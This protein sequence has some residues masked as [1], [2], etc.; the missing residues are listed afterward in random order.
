MASS[1]NSDCYHCLKSCT[2]LADL[3]V[4]FFASSYLRA[5]IQS[6]VAKL[7]Y[8]SNPSFLLGY[9]Q[10]ARSSVGLEYRSPKP[11]V[12]GSI[13]AGRTILICYRISALFYLS[14]LSSDN[15][16]V[17]CCLLIEPAW[18]TLTIFCCSAALLVFSRTFA[19]I[20]QTVKPLTIQ[21]LCPDAG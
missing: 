14:A 7:L 21:R 6:V 10:C 17:Y 4:Q 16:W 19:D 1:A 12:V 9:C 3:A 8:K 11:R 18:L 5:M 15:N 2:A 20:D 13:P